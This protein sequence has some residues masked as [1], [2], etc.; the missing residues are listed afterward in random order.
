MRILT[1]AVAASLLFSA[2]SRQ[3]SASEKPAP[4]T[5]PATNEKPVTETGPAKKLDETKYD[6]FGAGVTEGT[7]VK[8]ADV[9]ADPSA[10]EGK[11]V[12]IEGPIEAVCLQKGCWM[13]VGTEKAFAM[14]KFKDYGFFVPL[15]A[16]GRHAVL[17]GV[18]AVKQETVA[19]TK[20]YLEDAG[21]KEGAAKVTE[22]RKLVNVM[23]TGVAI[24]KPTK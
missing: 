16:S 3:S 1:I 8:V 12:R 19:E 14:V 15:D 4:T 13:H 20:H 7:N 23:A 21:D 24:T 2:C 17:E 18:V 9:L 5:T 22:G 10:Y 6:H 11:T